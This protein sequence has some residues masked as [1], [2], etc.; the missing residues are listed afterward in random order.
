MQAGNLQV[1][2]KYAQEIVDGNLDVVS[3]FIAKF[4][5][6]LTGKAEKTRKAATR[7]AQRAKRLDKTDAEVMKYRPKGTRHPMEPKMSYP[8]A[9]S[10]IDALE[11]AGDINAEEA[12]ARRQG[13]N[14]I[15]RVFAG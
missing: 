13:V 14:R 6:K 12:E 10:E 2:Q 4:E 15:R 1:Y 8:F 3:D 11:K 5:P 7:R 9:R